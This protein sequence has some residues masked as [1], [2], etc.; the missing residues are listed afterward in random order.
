MTE[1]IVLAINGGTASAVALDWTIARASR[2]PVVV[3]LVTIDESASPG[4]T[5]TSRLEAVR[6]LGQAAGRLADFAPRSKIDMVLRRG[7]VVDGLV[8]ESATADLIV[9]GS[10][11]V[12]ALE[13]VFSATLPLRLAPRSQCPV[14]VVPVGWLPSRGPVVVGVDEPTSA[15][16]REFAAEEAERIGRPL[17]L[18][19]ARELP[20][21]ITT[22]PGGPGVL[23][24]ALREANSQIL[25]GAAVAVGRKHGGLALKERLVYAPPSRAL[26]VEGRD[27]ELVV[28]GTRHSHALAEWMLGSV[29]HDLVMHLPCPVAIVPE[30]PGE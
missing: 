16:V 1:K 24:E 8:T 20:P 23:D 21:T 18:V 4:S 15:A 3:R 27:T 30:R 2:K 25:D 11:R 6:A 19:R 22:A 5:P 28:I 26:A 7:N 29:G 13:G 17:V 10:N 14:I 9:V 12:G